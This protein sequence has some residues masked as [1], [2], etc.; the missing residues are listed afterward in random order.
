MEGALRIGKMMHGQSRDHAVKMRLIERQV[1]GVAAT[2]KDVAQSEP[3]APP[4]CLLQHRLSC[5]KSHHGCG[6]GGNGCRDHTW[7]ACN[8]EKAASTCLAQ[9]AAKAVDHLI[10][11][12]LRPCIERVSL[13]PEFIANALQVMVIHA[14][15][16]RPSGRDWLS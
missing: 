12:L 3:R 8:V 5:I 16:L 4:S 13:S 9:R 2:E 15:F 11:C 14:I 6:A 10:V 1:L 7:P